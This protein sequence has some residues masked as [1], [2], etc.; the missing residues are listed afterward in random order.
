M[1]LL[2]RA[3]RKL[4]KSVVLNCAM[5]WL[6]PCYLHQESATLAAQGYGCMSL[7]PFYGQSI[8]DG[9]EDTLKHVLEQGVT[10]LNSSDLYGPYI[11]EELVGTLYF[12]YT[13]LEVTLSNIK[14]PMGAACSS[15]LL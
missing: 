5:Q 15:L 9:A 12:S 10:V 14:A 6:P 13:V 1:R 8:N 11:N 3:F 2:N 4:C 7:T